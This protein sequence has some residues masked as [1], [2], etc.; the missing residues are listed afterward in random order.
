MVAVDGSSRLH[1]PVASRMEPADIVPVP[2][3]V[4]PTV[5]L[6]ADRYF[7]RDAL[8]SPPG[9]EYP[10]NAERFAFFCRAALEW[11]R[12]LNPPPDVLHVHD[13]QAAPGPPFFR[14]PAP[15]YPELAPVLTLLT[16]HNPPYP[17]RLGGGT[18]A[19]LDLDTPHF[20]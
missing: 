8:Y 19:P 6:R 1:A 18:S 12:R 7:D 4:V 14:G 9:G 5:L 2:D 13:W 15:P 20:A 11:L 17:G 3:A 16:A 10:D